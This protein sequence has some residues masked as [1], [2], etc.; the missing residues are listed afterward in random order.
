MEAP[1]TRLQNHHTSPC[2]SLP[3]LVWLGHNSAL[4]GIL[5]I[6]AV[7]TWREL[8][9]GSWT[10]CKPGFD[11][12]AICALPSCLWDGPFSALNSGALT[13]AQEVGALTFAVLVRVRGFESLQS[14]WLL[15]DSRYLL[16]KHFL[17]PVVLFSEVNV[18]PALGSLTYSIEPS[19]RAMAPNKGGSFTVVAQRSITSE[20]G[21]DRRATCLWSGGTNPG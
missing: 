6:H 20:G 8:E 13:D 18:G 10:L 15:P 19:V 21:P 14:A 16:S 5:S 4:S 2:Q 3:A 1:A 17:W 9:P 7:L 12:S 11:L